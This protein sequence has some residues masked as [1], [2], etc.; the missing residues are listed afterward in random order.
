MRTSSCSVSEKSRP[1]AL[2]TP[3]AGGTSTCRIRSARAISTPVSGP[4][5][6][7]RAEREVARVAAAVGRD[8][9]HRPRHRRDGEHAGSRARPPRPSAR[10]APRRAARAPRAT[11]RVEGDRAAAE[12]RLVEVA[13][14]EQ[15]VGE[16]RLDA[17]HA[18]TDRARRRRRR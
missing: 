17:A 12:L 10:A 15:R 11:R 16:R 1:S 3:G 14:R 2:K 9:L 5:P 13:E 18:V 4:L 8:R 6:A 7:E